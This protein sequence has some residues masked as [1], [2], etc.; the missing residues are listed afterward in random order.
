MTGS[1]GTGEKPPSWF[2][3][4]TL[5][6]TFAGVLLLWLFLRAGH[7]LLGVIVW[8]G[9]M[10][11][12]WFVSGLVAPSRS[13]DAMVAFGGL[14]LAVSVV[15]ACTALRAFPIIAVS[16]A[17]LTL[18]TWKHR[19]TGNGYAALCLLGVFVLAYG[20]IGWY[21]MSQS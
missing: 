18:S 7:G 1:I 3:G 9:V 10:G 8:L 20:A 2:K 13:R 12:T 5:A 17:A 15:V 11:A 19:G 16:G 6:S 21:A 14:F 4:V